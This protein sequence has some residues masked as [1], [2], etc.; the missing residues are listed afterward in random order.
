[1]AR[2][3][4]AARDVQVD[5]N[6]GLVYRNVDGFAQMEG[7][8]EHKTAAREMLEDLLPNGVHGIITQTFDEQHVTVDEFLTRV[9]QDYADTLQLLGTTPMID[10]LE[11]LNTRFGEELKATDVKKVP[12]SDFKAALAVAQEEFAKLIFV[13]CAHFL[14]EPDERNR[15]LAPVI[16]QNERV[17]AYIKRRGTNPEIDPNTGEVIEDQDDD[18]DDEP[19]DTDVTPDADPVPVTE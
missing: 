8:S 19:V 6:L 16:E 11:R 3:K 12:F 5:R 18:A 2:Q 10:N 17:A 13:V 7:D 4:A 14:H 1:M 9:R 15:V